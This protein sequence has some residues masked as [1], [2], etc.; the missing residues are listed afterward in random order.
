MCFGTPFS[1]TIKYFRVI[2]FYKKNLTM[3]ENFDTGLKKA[4]IIFS[5]RSKQFEELRG[6]I[7]NGE[8]SIK[9]AIKLQL[10]QKRIRESMV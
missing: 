9:D 7:E 6:R 10:L 2:L 5:T 4:E 1:F 3:K 8:G